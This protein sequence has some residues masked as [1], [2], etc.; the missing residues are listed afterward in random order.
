M[1]AHTRTVSNRQSVVVVGFGFGGLSFVRSL[2]KH[3]SSRSSGNYDIIVISKDDV[4]TFTPLLPLVSEG[5][6]RTGSMTE[7]ISDMADRLGFKFVHSPAR[8]IDLQN[9]RVIT[10]GDEIRFDHLIIAT[11]STENYYGIPGARQNSLPLRR[12]RDARIIQSEKDGLVASCCDSLDTQFSG[13]ASFVIVGGGLSGVETAMSLKNALRVEGGNSCRFRDNGICIIEAAER[14]V[15]KEPEIVSEEVEKYLVYSG[16]RVMTKTKVSSIDHGNVALTDGTTI[17]AEEVIWTAG[18]RSNATELEI[19]DSVI[20]DRSGRI[21][22]DHFL[23]IPG[24]RE[25]Y[26]IGD[27]ALAKDRLGS[28][29]QQNASVAVQEGRYLGKQLAFLLRH[30]TIKKTRFDFRYFGHVLMLGNENLFISPGN[31]VIRGGL[32]RM[33]AFIVPMLDLFSWKN[34]ESLIMDKVRVVAHRRDAT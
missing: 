23:R 22:V 19:P 25:V 21:V 29:L 12:V 3:I 34:R 8:K 14:L 16:I 5:K 7:S 4:I 31:G 33:I 1:R 20:D 10:D 9:R 27:C 26:A 13:N 15:P 30:G 28:P 11:G 32:G 6:L 2:R 24:L 18:I 17:R